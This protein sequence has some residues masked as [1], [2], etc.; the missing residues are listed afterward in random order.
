MAR[1]PRSFPARGLRG[2]PASVEQVRRGD[3]KEA[4]PGHV[5]AKLL[6]GRQRFGHDCAHR[7]DRCFRIRAGRA[8]PISAVDRAFTPTVVR[9]FNL[10]DGARRQAEIGALARRIVDQAE[11][12][13]HHRCELVRVGRLVMAQPGLAERNERRV[14]RLVRT[15]LRAQTSRRSALRRAGSARP[16]NKRSSAHRGRGR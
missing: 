10:L 15:A 11:R 9:A 2:G 3:G 5:L 12:F 6:P 7:D 13:L 4:Q 16:G 1:L 8:Q 14:D